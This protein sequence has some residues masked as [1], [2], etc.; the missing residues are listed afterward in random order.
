MPYARA[1]DAAMLQL[2][3]RVIEE[4]PV[5]EI[6]RAEVPETVIE[7]PERISLLQ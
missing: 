6:P 2:V 4:S 1:F 3:T 5:M 7:F